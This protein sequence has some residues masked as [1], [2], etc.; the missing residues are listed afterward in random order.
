VG[1][2]A[3]ACAGCLPGHAA[4]HCRHPLGT[5]AAACVPTSIHTRDGPGHALPCCRTA[6]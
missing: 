6:P 5:C 3:R 1:Q 4:A 2:A